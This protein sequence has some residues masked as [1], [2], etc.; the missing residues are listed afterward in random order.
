M[1]M[2]RCI[3]EN[4]RSELQETYPNPL[5]EGETVDKANESAYPKVYPEAL[6]AELLA[7]HQK[8]SESCKSK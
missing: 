7:E 5:Y 1:E 6:T 4:G 3:I 2:A 8:L